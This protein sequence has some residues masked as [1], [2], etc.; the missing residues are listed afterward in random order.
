MSFGRL[1]RFSFQPITSKRNSYIYIYIY[2][3]I[4]RLGFSKNTLDKA[5]E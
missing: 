5:K 4:D 1:K 3:E 2:I